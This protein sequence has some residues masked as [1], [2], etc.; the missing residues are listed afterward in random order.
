MDT[1]RPELAANQAQSTIYLTQEEINLIDTIG[2][3]Q[4]V[5]TEELIT[6]FA[7]YISNTIQTETGAEAPALELNPSQ[8]APR[9]SQDTANLIPLTLDISFDIKDNLAFFAQ[10]RGYDSPEHLLE[11]CCRAS[12][13]FVR[14][15][16]N[17]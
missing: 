3:N 6:K 8:L 10:V 12:A 7:E 5:R 13:A 11:S 4:R 1:F 9:R 14:S 15:R 16:L 2:F 17:L